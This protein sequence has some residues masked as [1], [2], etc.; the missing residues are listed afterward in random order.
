MIVFG[1][2]MN[3]KCVGTVEWKN[4]IFIFYNWKSTENTIKLLWHNANN[5][6]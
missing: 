6:T 5:I 1:R 3:E 4:Y 2:H